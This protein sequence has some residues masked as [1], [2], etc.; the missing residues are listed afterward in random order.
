ML[1]HAVMMRFEGTPPERAEKARRAARW[2]REL[3]ERIPWIRR[4]EPRVDGLR[5][6]RSWDLLLLSAFDDADALVRYQEHPDHRAV[7]ERLR[8]LGLA[9]VAVVDWEEE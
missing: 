9:G 2:L 7:L 5:T 4:Y 6:D 1:H 8:G 3:P